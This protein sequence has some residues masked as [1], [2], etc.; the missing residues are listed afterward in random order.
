MARDMREWIQEVERALAVLRAQPRA[1]N[2]ALQQNKIDQLEALIRHPTFPVE[3]SFETAFYI[4][5]QGRRRSRLLVD[6]PDVTKATDATDIE[7]A[8]YELWGRDDTATLYE[9][10]TDALPGQAA[11]GLTL[12]G[13]DEPDNS[14]AINAE[15]QPWEMLSTSVQSYFRR[16]NFLP[17]SWWTFRVRAIGVGMAVPGEWS[18]EFLIQM[19]EDNTPPPQPTAPT[20]TSERGVLTV[21]WDGLSVLGT[22]PADFKYA[23]LA[24]G[25]ASSPTH[26][27]ARFDRGGGFKVVTAP[28]QTPQFFRVRAFDESGNAGPWSEQVVGVTTPLVDTDIILSKIDL[29][30]TDLDNFDVDTIIGIGGIKTRNITVTGELTAAIG[31][32]LQVKAGQIDVNEVWADTAW[33]GMANAKLVVSDMFV[34]KTFEGGTFTL[35]QGGKFQTNVEEFTGIKWDAAGIKAY[36]PSGVETFNLDAGTGKVT[37][38]GRFYSGSGDSPYISIIPAPDSFN[39]TQLAVLM[40][41]DSAAMAGTGAG[42]MYVIDA[43]DASPQQLNLRGMN[44][45]GVTVINGLTVSTITSVPQITLD[46][47]NDVILDAG[48]GN[49][50]NLRN[51]GA[52]YAMTS[53]SPANV[54]MHSTGQLFKSTSSLRYKLDVQPWDPG[55]AALGLELRSWVDRNPTDPS[56]PLHRYYGFIAEEVHAV[57]PEMAILNDYGEPEAVQYERIAGTLIPI[58]RDLVRRIEI[59]EGS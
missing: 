24:H 9:N 17:G 22:M 12:P 46:S 45:G 6:F 47:N 58:I 34:G 55:Y 43:T 8:T 11:P 53:S 7:I 39:T 59:L 16:E 35:T 15:P 14:A 48:A 2:E 54:Y 10:T 20:L 4:D 51:N 52:A 44:G 23:I 38:V 37:T 28:Y 49:T 29:A 5:V 31:E 25:D 1:F 3:L 13:L 56:D 19:H 36:S 41:R 18:Q 21:R 27:I 33:L 50:V 32:F 26:E 42:G 40:A 30:L 57:L